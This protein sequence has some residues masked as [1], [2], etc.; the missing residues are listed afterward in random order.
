MN[1]V[2][3]RIIGTMSIGIMTLGISLSA[4]AQSIKSEK[5]VKAEKESVVLTNQTWHYN[6]GPSDSPTDASKYTL[7]DNEPCGITQETVCKLFAPASPSNPNQPDMSASV[8]L[9]GQPSQTITQRINNAV[10]GS[11]K[12]TNETVLSLRPL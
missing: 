11:S 10:G 8:S 3:K 4:N 6:G 5:E 9:P 12:Q 7:D 2:V 1:K